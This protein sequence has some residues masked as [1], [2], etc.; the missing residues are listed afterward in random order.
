MRPS[1]IQSL[2]DLTRAPIRRYLEHI[3][4]QNAVLVTVIS[5]DPTLPIHEK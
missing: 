3:G 5:L 1:G 4:S 2:A